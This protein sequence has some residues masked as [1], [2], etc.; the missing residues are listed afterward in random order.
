MQQRKKLLLVAVSMSLFFTR[1]WEDGSL[2][3]GVNMPPAM[4]VA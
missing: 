2:K 4:A 3:Q 1:I